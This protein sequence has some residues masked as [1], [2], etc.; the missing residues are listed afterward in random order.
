MAA[1]ANDH[2]SPIAQE[3]ATTASANH[4]AVAERPQASHWSFKQVLEAVRYKSKYNKLLSLLIGADGV[5]MASLSMDSWADRSACLVRDG[6]GL[7]STSH[8]CRLMK[9]F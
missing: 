4:Q 2:H 3:L 1:A 9:S 8:T 6:R 5:S 7:M